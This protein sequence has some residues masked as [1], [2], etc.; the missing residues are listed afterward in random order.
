MD[1][2]PFSELHSDFSG[3]CLTLHSSLLITVGYSLVYLTE[4]NWTI[5]VFF[6]YAVFEQAVTELCSVSQLIDIWSPNIN[7]HV[8]S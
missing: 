5:K 4:S 3:R 7:H 1:L 6:N 8:P 2:V